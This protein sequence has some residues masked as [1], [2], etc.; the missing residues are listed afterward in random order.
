MVKGLTIIREEPKVLVQIDTRQIEVDFDQWGAKPN[1]SLSW[2]PPG[3]WEA[4]CRDTAN[5]KAGGTGET[6]NEVIERASSFFTE[7][8][9]KHAGETIAVI[10]HNGFKRLYMAYKL[11]MELRNYRRI[12]Q[13]NSAIT[14]FELDGGGEISL[15][16]LNT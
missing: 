15:T 9:Q 4:W 2:K 1:R 3:L 8:L 7:M 14:F 12:V 6:G 5:E 16:K 10:A 11:S 13:E